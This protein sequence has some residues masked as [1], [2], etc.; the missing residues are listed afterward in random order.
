VEGTI[1]NLVEGNY[2][3]TDLKGASALGNLYDGIETNGSLNNTIGGSAPGAGNVISG[4]GQYGVYIYG[5]GTDGNLVQGNKIGVAANGAALGNGDNGIYI[6]VGAANNTVGGTVAGAGN[7]I[8]N[9][10]GAGVLIYAGDG[11]AVLG[12]SLH[13]NASLGIDLYPPLGVT[14]NDPGDADSGTN[15]LQ[16]FP[17]LSSAG[18]DGSSTTVSG[19]LNSEAN[20]TYRI[21]FFANAGC[22]PSGYGEGQTYLGF[23]SVTT[24]GSGDASFNVTLPVASAAG[25][26]LTATA[27]DAT[28]DTSEFSACVTVAQLATPTPTATNTP[29]STATGTPTFTPTNTPTYTPTDTATP[30][31]TGTFTP[32]ATDTA[33]PTPTGTPT[34]TPTYTPT[35]TY[36]PTPSNTSTFTPTFTPTYTPSPTPAPIGPVTIDYTYDPLRRLTA[37]DYS[38]GDYD[39]YTYDPVGNRL[40]QSTSISGQQSSSSYQYDVANRLINVNG[41]DYTWD[42][43]GNLLNDGVN[44]YA[45]D[46]ANRLVSVSNA[47]GTATYSYNGFGDRLTQNGFHYTL[48]LN[49]GLTQVLDDGTDTYLYGVNRIVQVNG[50]DTNY[51]L[52]DALG[53]VRQLADQTGTITL[54]RNYDPYGN[55]VASAGN[56]TTAYGFTNEQQDPTGIALSVG[57]I[58]CQRNWKVPQQRYLAG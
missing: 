26:S 7:E 49:A 1:G 34:F 56:D 39:H 11:N 12:N 46:S 4:N 14:A 22:D 36:T 47:S 52:G 58:L 5:T 29:T 40:T 15:N 13:D 28:N 32:T 44:A 57:E 19:T 2:I 50:A 35:G 3:G 17:V 25:S 6:Q 31:P 16:N 41:V 27:T 55:V 23:T 37:A 42:N 20:G 43:N 18:S 51:F 48:D 24:N 33:T 10:N 54:A 21:E 45:Y 53:S 38:T 30:T 8:A 9:N